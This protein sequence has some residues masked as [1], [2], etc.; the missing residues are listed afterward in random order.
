[1]LHSAHENI[2]VV[3]SLMEV[4]E[5]QPIMCL[6]APYFTCRALEQESSLKAEYVKG[7]KQIS[8]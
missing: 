4:D 5:Q 7:K 2:V 6:P 1:M 3:S 8:V